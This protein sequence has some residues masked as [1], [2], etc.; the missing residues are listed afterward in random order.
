MA[1]AKLRFRPI[2]ITSTTTLVGLLP[3]AYGILG[4]NSY[5]TPMVMA[6]AW[7]VLFGGLVSL[8]LLPCLYAVD[9]DLR[10][11][12]ARRLQADGPAR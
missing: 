5:M 2:L 1:A 3:T 8:I 6:M 4:E 10:R 11:V 12:F 7:G 9:Q